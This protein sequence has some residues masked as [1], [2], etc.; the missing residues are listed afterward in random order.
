MAASHVQQHQGDHKVDQRR[1]HGNPQAQP[2]RFQGLRME[3]PVV[4]GHAYAKGGNQ[5][6]RAFQSAGEIFGL[7]MAV[8]MLVVG[9]LRGEGEHGEGHDGGD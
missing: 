9:R 7:A 3:Q 6:Q 2:Q 1:Q 5:D 4:S 8:M